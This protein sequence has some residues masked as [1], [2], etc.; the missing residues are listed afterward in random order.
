[1]IAGEPV[2]FN[3]GDGLVTRAVS[4]IDQMRSAILSWSDC[5]DGFADG[6]IPEARRISNGPTSPASGAAVGYTHNLAHCFDRRLS[7]RI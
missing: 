7:I 5:H 3:V 6:G 2:R 4:S 1:M